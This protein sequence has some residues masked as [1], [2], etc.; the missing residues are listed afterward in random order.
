MIFTSCSHISSFVRKLEKSTPDILK[1]DFHV[2]WFQNFEPEYET[3]NFPLALNSPFLFE[4]ILYCG[5]DSEEMTAFEADTGHLIWKKKDK[6]AHRGVPLV[7]KEKL[8]YGTIDGRVYAR[9]Y[10]T[11]KT[12]YDVDLGS[13]IESHFTQGQERL[14]V[15]TRNHKVYSLDIGT[16]KILWAYK[17]PV[18]DF[19]TLQGAAGLALYNNSVIVSFADGSIMS[20]SIEEGKILWENTSLNNSNSVN[21]STNM[22]VKSSGLSDLDFTPLIVGQNVFLGSQAHGL[23]ILNPRTGEFIRRLNDLPVLRKPWYDKKKNLLLVGTSN[24]E[25]V[26]INLRGDILRKSKVSDFALLSIISWNNFWIANSLSGKIYKIDPKSLQ[27]KGEFNLGSSESVIYGDLAFENK[28]F[29]AY[30]SRN[31]LYVFKALK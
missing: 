4:G 25:I 19:I 18:S 31:R 6:G 7:Y 17:R 16:G 12:I 9:H 2:A 24:G 14:F 13:P 5:G 10:L 22:L 26:E 23:I 3:G 30:S 1:K 21:A 27:V 11:G 15:Q 28:N 20:F 29:A 8:I